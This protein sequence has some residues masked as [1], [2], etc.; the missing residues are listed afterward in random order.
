VKKLKGG[1][2]EGKKIN[3]LVKEVGFSGIFGLK[4][5][6]L[7]ESAAKT[8]SKK[9]EVILRSFVSIDRFFCFRHEII[10]NLDSNLNSYAN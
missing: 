4:V 10:C 2:I 1:F 5:L 8:G 7:G 6:N 3:E 9:S